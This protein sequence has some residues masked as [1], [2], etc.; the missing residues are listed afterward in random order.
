[1]TRPVGPR[2]RVAALACLLLSVGAATAV[3]QAPA[4]P[5]PI[6]LGGAVVSGALRSRTYSWNWFGDDPSGDYV[7]QGS[8]ARFGL[9]RSHKAID[10]QVEFEVPFILNLPTTAVKPPPQGQL[11]LGAA[12]YAAND[13]SENTAALFLKQGF[14]RFKGLGGVAGQSL[15]IGRMEFNDGLEVLPKNAA[16]ATLKR[17]RISQR[18]LG[19]FGFSDVLRSL[20][21]AQYALSTPKLNVTAL[22]ARPTEGVF[23]VDGWSELHINVFY[24]TVTGEAGTDRHPA[25]WRVFALG[26]DDYR[27]GVVKTDNRPLAARTADTGSIVVGTYGGNYLQAIA[28]N[29]GPIDLLFWGALQT[30][31][32]GSLSHHAGA[33]ALEGGWQPAGLPALKPWIRGGYDWGSGD[34]DAAD[35]RHGS[36]FQV[37][38]TARIY[39]RMPFY[40]L[41]NTADAF[42]EVILRPSGKLTL[43]TDVHDLQLAS[44]SDLWYPA[45]A[46]SS[47]ARS[48][49]TDGRPTATPASP[50]CTTRAATTS[51]TRT[52]PSACTTDTL[53][54]GTSPRQSTPPTTAVTLAM[55]NC[56]CV[57]S[58]APRFARTSA[59]YARERCR[60][61]S[62][63]MSRVERS[64]SPFRVPA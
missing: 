23:Q 14:V 37:L 39:A 25:E 8:Q 55:S 19:N 34:A 29:A 58:A 6:T 52:S 35:G 50:R 18:V 9:S 16:L 10:W 38:P 27:Q 3:A 32:W 57:S 46:R 59:C 20:D 48:G 21:G 1:M 12:Y 62:V 43:R 40:N 13:N 4:A 60:R 56:S 51:S 7:Y 42:G 63:C 53:R 2:L 49:S 5:K 36:F 44:A 61:I 22:A 54:A 15:R 45:A 33:V 11:G 31:S 30:G 41:M 47:R 26:Y 24:G 28:T 64:L 17:D